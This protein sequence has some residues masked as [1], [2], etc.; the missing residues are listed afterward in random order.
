M[1]VD[2][3][4]TAKEYGRYR[5]VFP[6]AFFERLSTAW[7]HPDMRSLADYIRLANLSGSGAGDMRLWPTSIYSDEVRG[8]VEAGLL[9]NG[10][11]WSEWSVGFA[12]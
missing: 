6:D 4:K 5:S 3:G 8:K 12:A 11:R 7:N 2:F 10:V 1:G 9:A